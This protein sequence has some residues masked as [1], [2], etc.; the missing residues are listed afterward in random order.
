MAFRRHPDET[1]RIREEREKYRLKAL[2]RPE[3]VTLVALNHVERDAAR[4]VYETLMAVAHGEY[5]KRVGERPTCPGLNCGQVVDEI[6]HAI[7]LS[8]VR[9]AEESNVNLR[10]GRGILGD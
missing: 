2:A 4:D 7:N 8:R 9:Q 5:E 3:A 10:E 1:E 6:V